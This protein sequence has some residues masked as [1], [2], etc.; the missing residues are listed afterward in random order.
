MEGHLEFLAGDA[1]L[2]RMT[3]TAS[4]LEAAEYVAQQFTELGL[5]P[6]GENGWFQQVPL[7]ANRINVEKSGVTMHLDSGDSGLT[8]KEDYVMGGDKVRDETSV[9]A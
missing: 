9:R 4:Y 2:G 7:L 3:G 5:E 8:W 1:R 6:A